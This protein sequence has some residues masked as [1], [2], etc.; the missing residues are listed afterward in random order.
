MTSQ[1]SVRPTYPLQEHAPHN[2][3]TNRTDHQAHQ[4]KLGATNSRAKLEECGRLQGRKNSTG[5]KMLFR[6]T[7]YGTKYT[8]SSLYNLFGNLSDWLGQSCVASLHRAWI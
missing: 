4:T 3:H 7:T 1:C 8:I 6:E 5:P 2:L